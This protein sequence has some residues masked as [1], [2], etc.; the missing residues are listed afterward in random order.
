MCKYIEDYVIGY[1]FFML[2]EFF[3]IFYVEQCYFIEGVKCFV[4][5]VVLIVLVKNKI[6]SVKFYNI[7]LYLLLNGNIIEYINYIQ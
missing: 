1:L 2:I 3:I 7:V 6:C 5:D 4:Y